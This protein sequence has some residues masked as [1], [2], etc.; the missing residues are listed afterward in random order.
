MWR[1]HRPIHNHR[2][3]SGLLRLAIRRRQTSVDRQVNA[4]DITRVI[5]GDKSSCASGILRLTGAAL[6]NAIIEALMQRLIS[7]Y[8]FGKIG[9]SKARANGVV[10]QHIDAPIL[11]LRHPCRLR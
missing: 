2:S 6:Q 4:G 5:A 9:E 8:L 1:D 11:P 3:G 10:N 7:F